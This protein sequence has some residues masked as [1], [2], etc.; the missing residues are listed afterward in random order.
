[1]ISREALGSA[2]KE[3]LKRMKELKKERDDKLKA[4]QKE[5]CNVSE[6]E[7]GSSGKR[8]M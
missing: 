4:A 5:A 1:M 7:C 8:E 3:N 2:G 6:L